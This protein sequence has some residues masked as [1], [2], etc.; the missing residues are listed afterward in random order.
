MHRC[1]R[2]TCNRAHYIKPLFSAFCTTSSIETSIVPDMSIKQTMQ[3]HF[4][5]FSTSCFHQTNANA[6]HASHIVL[7]PKQFIQYAEDVTRLLQKHELLYHLF[8]DDIQGMLH[9]PP[10]DVP[11]IVS[12]PTDCFTDVSHWCA[13]KRLQ[14][15][16]SK[17]EV[18]W[19][20][21][22]ANLRKIPPGKSILRAGSSAIDLA[23][24][25]RNLGLTPS[26]RCASMSVE[27]HKYVSSTCVSCDPC[28]LN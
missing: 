3:I 13:A 5:H 11:R 17:T 23:T 6:L 26:Y 18:L 28:V 19:F 4:N 27:L 15:N 24:V 1:L 22:A 2:F 12:T 16:D 10:A 14:L 9:G 20:G 8:A 7:G 21:S 25:V